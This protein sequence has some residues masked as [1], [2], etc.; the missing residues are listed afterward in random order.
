MCVG[1]SFAPFI[2]DESIKIGLAFGKYCSLNK[3]FIPGRRFFIGQRRQDVLQRDL[4][5]SGFSKGPFKENSS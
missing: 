1:F 4:G 5:T 3:L 2:S